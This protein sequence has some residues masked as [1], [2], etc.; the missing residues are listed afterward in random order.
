MVV[1]TDIWWSREQAQ[2]L[3]AM[4]DA[5]IGELDAVVDTPDTRR[6][7]RRQ[8]SDAPRRSPAGPVSRAYRPRPPPRRCSPEAIQPAVVP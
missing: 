3:E 5:R 1:S 2:G 7:V 6:L 4:R 8:A